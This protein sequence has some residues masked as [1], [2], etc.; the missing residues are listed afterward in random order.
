MAKTKSTQKRADHRSRG[1]ITQPDV[2]Q[3]PGKEGH[4]E[5]KNALTRLR[6]KIE[7]KAYR[8]P[9]DEKDVPKYLKVLAQTAGDLVDIYELSKKV[10]GAVSTQEITAALYTRI[11]KRLNEEDGQ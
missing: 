7:D 3:C 10:K 2:Y 9:V 5:S 4:Q 6:V 1:S 11:S 8:S